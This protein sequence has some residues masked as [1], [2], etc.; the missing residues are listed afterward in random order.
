[1]RSLRKVRTLFSRV[2]IFGDLWYAVINHT[3]NALKQ[4]ITTPLFKTAIASAIFNMLFTLGFTSQNALVSIADF[5]R[6]PTAA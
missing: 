2:A 3:A 6:N 5:Q 4:C 1:M